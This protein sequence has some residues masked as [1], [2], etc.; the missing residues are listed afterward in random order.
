MTQETI[1]KRDDLEF[2]RCS[3]N[4]YCITFNIKNNDMILSKIINF[5]LLKLVYD[6]NP[7]IYERT[8]MNIIDENNAK[9]VILMKYFF[10]DLGMAQ[11]YFDLNITKVVDNDDC[12]VFISSRNYDHDDSLPEFI[13][14]EAKH[15]P[16]IN[17]NFSFKKL[18]NHEINFSCNILLQESKE[19]IPQ[20][21]ENF[22]G[23]ILYKIFKRVKLFIENVKI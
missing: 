19:K 6:L 12:T 11:T 2:I 23:Q 4:N 14:D 8:T 1:F 9:T 15:F 3:E 18:S 16:I 13:P 17:I 21:I 20:I 5:D 22:I 7:D 10:K